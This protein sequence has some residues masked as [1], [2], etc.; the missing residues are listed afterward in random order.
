M[1]LEKKIKISDF[2]G[3]PTNHWYLCSTHKYTV[4]IIIIVW[5]RRCFFGVWDLQK[6]KRYNNY[7]YYY[8]K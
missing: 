1:N 8:N 7:N 4:V 2:Y 3:E 5:E 6:K